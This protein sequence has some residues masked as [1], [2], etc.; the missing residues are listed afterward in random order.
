MKE[1]RSFYYFD[2]F[3]NETGNQ[4]GQIGIKGQACI[5]SRSSELTVDDLSWLQSVCSSS[6][7][8]MRRCTMDAYMSVIVYSLTIHFLLTKVERHV[9]LVGFSLQSLHMHPQP[10]CRPAW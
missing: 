8:R 2:L 9:V 1:V 6:H 5:V 4:L 3:A 7:S 10:P